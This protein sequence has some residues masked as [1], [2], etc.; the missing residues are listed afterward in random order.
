MF[1]FSVVE[2]AINYLFNKCNANDDTFRLDQNL[3][4]S[5]WKHRINHQKNKYRFDFENSTNEQSSILNQLILRIEPKKIHTPTTFLVNTIARKLQTVISFIILFGFSFLLSTCSYRIRFKHTFCSCSRT[6]C[7]VLLHI[8]W[9]IAEY[10]CDI[11]F[12][13][14]FSSSSREKLSVETKK[15]NKSRINW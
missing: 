11:F 14:C 7:N 10:W 15:R 1:A 12:S 6:M 5:Y 13:F 9:M 3:I 2:P 4:S 8:C